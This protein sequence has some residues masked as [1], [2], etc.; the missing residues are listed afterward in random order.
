MGNQVY[1]GKTQKEEDNKKHIYSQKISCQ[2]FPSDSWYKPQE[3]SKFAKAKVRIFI[4]DFNT[5]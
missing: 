3:L 4:M 1:I 5:M 2:L